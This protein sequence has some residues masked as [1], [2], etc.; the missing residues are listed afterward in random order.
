MNVLFKWEEHICSEWENTDDY[1]QGVCGRLKTYIVRFC[2]IIH[3]M[4][5]V[6][7]ETNDDVINEDIAKSAC[8]LADYFLE[9]DKR[10]HNIRAVPVD[11]A[12][13]QLFD[14]LPDS[15]TT[16]EAVA[17]GNALGL[18]ERTVKRFLSNGQNSY[19]KKDRHGIYSKME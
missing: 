10:V 8:L 18:S 3:V 4:R 9:M 5:L 11:V 14:S 7:K 16:S 2:L 15:F 6:C 19:L 12:H 17:K 13:Q 1:M